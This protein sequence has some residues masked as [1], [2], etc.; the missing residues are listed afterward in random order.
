MSF[1][2]F[3]NGKAYFWPIKTRSLRRQKINIFQN[4]ITHGFGPKTATFP[5]FFQALYARKMSFTIFQNEKSPFQAIKTKSS[6]SRK[7]DIFL[8]GITHGFRSKNGHLQKIFFL[9]N[10]GLENVFY[11]ILERKNTFLAYKNQTFKKS[12][13]RHFSKGVNPQ[14]WS[15]NGHFY[16][17]F[18]FW[19]YRPGKCLLGYFTMEKH[20]SGL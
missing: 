13:N 12:K 1:T 9:G 16:N 6:K 15:K 20:L 19:Q 11:D 3:Y 10:I 8:K 2:I 18:I 14:F 17:I 4:G 5:I 7:I